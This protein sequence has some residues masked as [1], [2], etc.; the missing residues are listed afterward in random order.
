MNVGEELPTNVLRLT[1]KVTTG[2]SLILLS[3]IEGRSSTSI[4]GKS[5]LSIAGKHALS[6]VFADVVNFLIETLS[7]LTK[8]MP[9]DGIVNPATADSS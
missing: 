8:Y 5:A 6:I 7:E 2:Q 9:F 1:L 3:G 4:A